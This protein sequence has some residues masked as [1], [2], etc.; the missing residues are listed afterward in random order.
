MQEQQREAGNDSPGPFVEELERER[1]E[2]LQRLD[3]WL[4]TPMLVLAFVWLA[5]FVYEMIYGL[6]RPLE[7]ASYVIWALFILEFVLGFTVAPKKVAFLKRNWLKAIALLAPALR[8]FR[9]LRVLRVT[10]LAGTVRGVQLVRVIGAL[11]RSM[12]A[13][14]AALSRRGFGYVVGLTVLLALVGAAGMYGFERVP[15][16]GSGFDNYWSALW[17]T[18]MLMTSIGSEYWPQ[19][20]EGRA[21]C[22]LL[23]IYG[24][25]VFGYVTATLATFFIGRDAEDEAAEVAGAKAVAAL[26]AEISALREEIVSLGTRRM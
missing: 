26:T 15:A 22:L 19:T 1:Y 4:E 8:V 18:A 25:A 9:V 24:F 16:D 5:I 10:R 13:F 2:L 7:I 21:L 11:N 20:P 14:G 3:D 23:A 12:N 6:V 17:W